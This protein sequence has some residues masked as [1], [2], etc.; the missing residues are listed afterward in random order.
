M[1]K[2]DVLEIKNGVRDILIKSGT[3]CLCGRNE[4]CSGCSP[5][6]YENNILD[7]VM[8]YFDELIK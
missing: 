8:K 2:E 4:W 1:K 3:R 6:S 5:S 7:K